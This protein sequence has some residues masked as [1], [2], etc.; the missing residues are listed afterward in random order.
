MMK[1]QGGIARVALG[2]IMAWLLIAGSVPVGAFTT[3]LEP[4]ASLTAGESLKAGESSSASEA[5]A[6]DEPASD[7]RVLAQDS[8]GIDLE[9]AAPDFEWVQLQDIEGICELPV[10]K[11]F[12]EFGQAG[13][14]ALPATVTYVGTPGAAELELQILDVKQETLPGIHRVCP[15]AT[16]QL[17]FALGSV[18]EY[19]GER[20]IPDAELYA[21]SGFAP[22]STVELL[23]TS[24][25]RG[26]RVAEIRYMPIQ[27][28]PQT[29]QIRYTQ[30]VRVRLHFGG[31]RYL[32]QLAAPATPVSAI[33][34]RDEAFDAVLRELLVNYET[35]RMW[36]AERSVASYPVTE[37]R[38]VTNPQFK[39]TIRDTGLYRITYAALTALDPD[40]PWETVDPRK[41]HLRNQGLE[42]AIRVEGES[43][44]SF[45]PGDWILFY[46][47]KLIS[48]YALD[49]VYWL[50]WDDF[51]G[52]RMTSENGAPGSGSTPAYFETTKR[53]EVDYWYQTPLP[54]GDDD[55]WYWDYVQWSGAINRTYTTP[56]QNVVTAPVSAT[57]RGLLAGYAAI[58]AHQVRVLL[59]SHQ[60]Y[61]ATW[62]SGTPHTFSV[63]VPSSYILEG[64]N[65]IVLNRWGTPAPTADT[66][67]LNWL[68]LDY[69][70]NYTATNDSLFFDGDS[71]GIWK[72]RV[73]GFTSDLLEVYDITNPLAPVRITGA[74]TAASGGG[75]ALTF[76]RTIASESHYLALATSQILAPKKLEEDRSSTWRSANN[77][78]DYIIIAPREF[79]TATQPLADYHAAE[80]LRVEIVDIQD[81]YDEFGF[82]WLD[83]GA[84]RDFVAYAYAY[85]EA[86]APAYVLL[87]GD[88]NYDYRDNLGRAERNFVPPYMADVDPWM[89]ETAADNRYVAVDGSDIQP[90]LHLGRLPAKTAVEVTT[91]VNKALAYAADTSADAWKGRVL[92]V[93][94]NPDTGGNFRSFSDAVADYYVPAPYSNQKIYYGLAPYTSGAT[95]R[96]AIVNAIKSGKLMVN[97]IG[98]SAIQY[99]AGEQLMNLTAI[100]SLTNTQ[101]LPFMTPMTCYEG[102]YIRPTGASDASSVGESFVRKS[103]G[104]AIASWSPT[105]LGVANG[106]DIINKAFYQAAF[107]EDLTT[108]GPATTLS[109]L[110]LTGMG[111]N[112]LI[113]T[114]ILFGDP[115]LKLNVLPADVAISKTVTP[116]TPLYPGDW[117]TYTL[118]FTN[119]GPARANNVVLEDVLPSMLLTPTVASSGATITRRPSTQYI[120]DVA[121]LLPGAGGRITITAQIPLDYVGTF[122]NTAT[123]NTTARELTSATGNNST[124]PIVVE[125]VAADVEIYK[126]GPHRATPG[127]IITYVLTYSNV[128]TTIATGVVITDLLHSHVLT[129]VVT[130][131]GPTITPRAGQPFVW[132]VAP[133]PPGAQGVITITATVSMGHRGLLPNQATIATAAPEV[134]ESNNTSALV[135]TAVLIPELVLEKF[136]PAS[137]LPGMGITYVLTY[138][139]LG[140]EVATS[141]VITDLLPAAIQN[142]SVLSAGTVI[143]QLGGSAYVWDVADIPPGSSGIITLTG[144]IAP[145]FRGTLVNTATI[146]AASPD[147]DLENNSDTLETFVS[148]ADVAI[149]KSGPAAALA[150]EH[151][152]YTLAFT[153]TDTA[154]ATG[155]VITDTLPA[156]LLDVVVTSSLP[157]VTTWPG[158]AFVWDIPDLAPGESGMLI[159]TGRAAPTYRGTLLNQAT[160]GTTAPEASNANN[161][162]ALVETFVSMADVTIE[163]TG[164]TTVEAGG[165]VTYTLQYRNVDNGIATGVVLTDVLPSALISAAVTYSG[166]MITPR[167]GASFAW[168]VADLAP[169]VGGVVTITA[170][171]RS[172]ATGSVVNTASIA[173]AGELNTADNSSAPVGTQ[174]LF[175]DVAIHK[176]APATVEPG[177]LITYRLTF[178]NT[179]AALAREVVITDLLPAQLTGVSFTS[180]G[181]VVTPRGGAPFVW[182]VVDLAPGAGGVITITAMVDS[183]FT[184]V[185]TNTA[186]IVTTGLDSDSSNDSAQTSTE[187]R[188]PDYKV[189]L[190]LV[191]RQYP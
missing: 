188:H 51:D 164:P 155:V 36:R 38:G 185:L 76:E 69:T 87:V 13:A 152:T 84:I 159:V 175:P 60:V 187:V 107:Y 121:D 162:S 113:D 78:A 12:D 19:L 28:D 146:F 174:I 7:P 157:G 72:Y 89:G 49:N 189:Y 92:F 179:G 150:G 58:P 120:W 30:R 100:A 124:A 37:V 156:S 27:F 136:G 8:L 42:V 11:G 137:A 35:A 109:K 184:G 131:S 134:N 4:P 91:M 151:I 67:F 173:A 41:F 53:L 102:Y 128:G 44:G 145:T 82:G 93:A 115:A 166:P 33:A 45:D 74:Q 9:F 70:R 21:L 2:A 160:I 96:T 75:Y 63:N 71:S 6:V 117:L 34:P 40:Y 169:G 61:S 98:H 114:Y 64:T 52:Q 1:R 77:A 180:S 135:S 125:A 106:H 171:V 86:P 165:V 176:S 57:L 110:A 143:T 140:N 149:A 153:N 167:P 94:D 154:P 97:Y 183:A 48:K 129:P 39:V 65:T 24:V 20:R 68:E 22:E 139:N 95:T 10:I 80:G 161:T 105:G 177:A 186:T 88:G 15:A 111:H 168:T 142:V 54:S 147:L 16:P 31:E 59:N 18:P 90:D 81:I 5:L 191:T 46:G 112:E 47:E 116:T 138:V 66:Y 182:D 181:V 132:D 50:T 3:A 62:A 32:T 55:R 133:L 127:E 23:G 118:T 178:T 144:T 26:Q 79:F 83:P 148:I 73:G 158:S 85:W 141:V 190:P 103:G 108:F 99:W 17:E 25:I 170:H 123:I 126:V 104:G 56:L 163:K 43:D 122:T 130:F 119:T 29:G 14:P 172:D 101:T